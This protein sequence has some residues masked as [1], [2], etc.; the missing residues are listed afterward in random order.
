MP[1]TQPTLTFA[2]YQMRAARLRAIAERIST[3]RTHRMWRLARLAFG[4]T[5]PDTRQPFGMNVVHNAMI[6]HGSGAN[7]GAR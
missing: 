6:S 3:S 2:E 7:R 1:A 4:E 5:G